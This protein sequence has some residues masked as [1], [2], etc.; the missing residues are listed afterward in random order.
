MNLLREIFIRDTKHK[1]YFCHWPQPRNRN[2]G[3]GHEGPGRDGDVG[4]DDVL[5]GVRVGRRDGYRGL[6]FVVDLVD[7]LVEVA[8]MKKSVGN[9][10]FI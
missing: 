5:D 10:L 9:E 2:R 4:G 7:V 8:M 6:P 1:N 3:F